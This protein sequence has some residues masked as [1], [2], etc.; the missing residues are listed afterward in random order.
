[1]N[2]NHPKAQ[3]IFSQ[4]IHPF[5]NEKHQ[6]KDGEI[7]AGGR[8]IGYENSKLIREQTDKSS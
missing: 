8:Y 6:K 2:T 7:N 4:N 3:G 1:M 5:R